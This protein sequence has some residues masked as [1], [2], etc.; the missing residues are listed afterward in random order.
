MR[1]KLFKQINMPA[2]EK[3]PTKVE[4]TL[5]KIKET[6]ELPKEKEAAERLREPNK[7]IFITGA[8]GF[9]GSHTAIELLR[10]GHKLSLLSRDNKDETAE[11]RIEKA[12]KQ[13]ASGQEEYEKYKS[14]I[15]VITG[16]TG[17]E[18]LGLTNDE[19]MKLGNFDEVLHLAADLSFAE[20]D[21]ERI[22]QT[23]VNGTLNILNFVEKT[24]SKRI[25]FVS[26]A[27]VC[28]KKEGNIE[29]SL[30]PEDQRPK[31]NNPYEE[32]KYRAEQIVQSWSKKTNI[33]A[34]IIRP[35]IIVKK[36]ETSSRF[37]Y[38]AFAS[39]FAFLRQ[40]IILAEKEIEFPCNLSSSIN[41]ISIQD[42]TKSILKIINKESE[43][44]IKIFHLTNPHPPSTQ[45]L[46]ENSFEIL[47]LSN[48]IKMINSEEYIDSEYYS[49]ELKQGLTK[50]LLEILHDLLPYLYLKSNFDTKNINE[51][52]NY[53][54]SPEKISKEFLEETLK[55]K[56]TPDSKDDWLRIREQKRK[57]DI[58]PKK[59]RPEEI[60]TG[61]I[62]QKAINTTLKIFEKLINFTLIPSGIEDIQKLY[63]SEAKEYKLKHH[64]TT[65]FKDT[66]IRKES[67]QEVKNYLENIPGSNELKI[68]DI[69]T[70]IGLTL[71]EL[72]KT[73]TDR[74]IKLYGIDYTEAMLKKGEARLLKKGGRIIL[75]KGNAMQLAG[76]REGYSENGFYRFEKNSIDCA[77]IVFGIGGIEYPEKCFEELLKIL[78]T[79]GAVIMADIHAPSLKKEDVSGLFFGLRSPAFIQQSWEKITKPIV[80]KK[81]WGWKD[82]TVSFH[83]LPL[84]IYFDEKENK[85][86]GFKIIKQETKNL[87]WW[88]NL[89]VMPI[90]K[91]IAQKIE[92]PRAEF[93]IKQAI[94]KK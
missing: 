39:A 64:I 43:E 61:N 76:E 69:A 57:V 58:I 28:G 6:V 81:L 78:K 4:E 92:I 15:K 38:Y 84:S 83:Q 88:L 13:V 9:A 70:G 65:A 3:K 72:D 34:T 75:K 24:G 35:S 40:E 89:P 1:E 44:D 55:Y 49:S 7:T 62:E 67:A 94:T 19:I 60:K 73:I 45:E 79:N 59:Y 30:I 27:Y 17:K 50:K 86:Y 2:L 52:F 66:I 42:A 54:Y 82:P 91:I 29:E 23:N 22:M 56:Y 85:Y 31:F 63:S 48:K 36:G 87:K 16:D 32:S 80:L 46:F 33:P 12:I 90:A 25:N 71:E 5:E 68:I 10:Q 18:N 26:T 41:I 53:K 37:G 47:G 14:S 11:Q 77:T 8:T 74:N 20:K 21:R 51:L 93:L